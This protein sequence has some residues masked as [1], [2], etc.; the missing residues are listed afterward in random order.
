MAARR[1]DMSIKVNSGQVCYNGHLS[2]DA[3]ADVEVFVVNR[4]DQATM[5]DTFVAK[6]GRQTG[7]FLFLPGYNDR[8]V[9]DFSKC[10]PEWEAQC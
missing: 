5:L 10:A 4:E 6:G 9:G 1:W 2:V 3:F 8:P 7:P